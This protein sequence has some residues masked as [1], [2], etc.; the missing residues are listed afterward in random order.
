MQNHEVMVAEDTGGIG[1]TGY[2]FDGL[3]SKQRSGS[4]SGVCN[5]TSS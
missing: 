3:C 2:S 5:K 1:K 4:H